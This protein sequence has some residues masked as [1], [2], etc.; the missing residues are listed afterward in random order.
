MIVRSQ[1]QDIDL[2]TLLKQ[3]SKLAENSYAQMVQAE[4]EEK[5]EATIRQCVARINENGEIIR[6]FE[7]AA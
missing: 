7:K 2:D 3:D 4:G 6:S 5:A 1:Y